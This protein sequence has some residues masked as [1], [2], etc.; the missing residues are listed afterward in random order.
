VPETPSRVHLL[1]MPWETP[2]FVVIRMDAELA[3][4]YGDPTLSD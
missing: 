3:A 1:I 4:Y 2:R